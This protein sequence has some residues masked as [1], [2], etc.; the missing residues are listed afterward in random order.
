[1]VDPVS[2]SSNAGKVTLSEWAD[3]VHSDAG[4]DEILQT[5]LAQDEALTKDSFTAAD[6]K[7]SAIF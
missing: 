7:R 6:F 4:L 5:V 2:E 3:F 1:M